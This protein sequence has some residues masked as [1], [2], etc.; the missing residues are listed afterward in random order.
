M[1]TGIG[2]AGQAEA[3]EGGVL[4]VG[5]DVGEV[6]EGGHSGGGGGG[7]GGGDGPKAKDLRWSCPLVE[8]DSGL[9]SSGPCAFA[10]AVLDERACGFVGRKAL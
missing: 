10:I 3:G 8:A 1:E 9:I 2:D 5:A 4:E 6:D 7:G